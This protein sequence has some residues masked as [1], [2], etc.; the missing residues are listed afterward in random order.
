MNISVHSTDQ[1]P[2]SRRQIPDIPA[3]CLPVPGIFC[4]SKIKGTNFAEAGQER[5]TNEFLQKKQQKKKKKSKN[6]RTWRTDKSTGCC[7]NPDFDS[8]ASCDCFLQSQPGV[9]VPCRYGRFST[10]YRRTAA[11]HKSVFTAWDRK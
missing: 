7:R 4:S 10:G 2:V 6:K 5:Q 1:L 11:R 8:A 9:R 3:G